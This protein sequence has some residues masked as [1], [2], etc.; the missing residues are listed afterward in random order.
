Q[1]RAS[2]WGRVSPS[3]LAGGWSGADA[4]PLQQRL[5]MAGPD[6]RAGYRFRHSACNRDIV[7]P[8]FAGTL[9]AACDRVILAQAEYRGHISLHWSYGSSVPEDEAVKSLFTLQ[10]PDLVVLGDAGQAWL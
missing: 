2:R 1:W 10:G 9:V 5:P 3:L 8:A 6:P 4:R 7:E